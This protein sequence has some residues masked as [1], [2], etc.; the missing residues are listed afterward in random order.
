VQIDGKVAGIAL[1]YPYIYRR[2]VEPVLLAALPRAARLRHQ[3][4]AV[5]P[6]A[7][8]RTGQRIGRPKRLTTG[9]SWIYNVPRDQR[10]PTGTQTVRYRAFGASG[11]YD[12]TLS[13]VNGIYT[14]DYYR[15]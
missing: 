4:A 6:D 10:H 15:C 11:C 8:R 9:A 2:L 12:H 7:L 14:E 5:R 13:A 3:A 1:P